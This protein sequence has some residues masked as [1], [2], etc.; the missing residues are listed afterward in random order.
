MQRF[1]IRYLTLVVIILLGA[2]CQTSTAQTS[3]F[4][5]V[6]VSVSGYQNVPGDDAFFDFF[7]AGF[8]AGVNL[9]TPFYIGTADLGVHWHKYR[10]NLVTVPKMTAFFLSAGWGYPISMGS[11]V[12]EPGFRLGNYRMMFDL[13]NAFKSEL[14][15]SEFTTAFQARAQIEL[16]SNVHLNLEASRMTVYTYNRLYFNYLGGGVSYRLQ[17]GDRLQEA[18]R[19]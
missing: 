10:K 9:R 6:D 8:G 7:G 12:I 4:S 19:K 1:V 11:V 16:A 14:D 18:L 3:P 2:T 15:E 5:Y 17:I 13:D